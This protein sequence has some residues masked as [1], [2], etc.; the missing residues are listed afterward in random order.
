M[1][2]Q[3]IFLTLKFKRLNKNATEEAGGKDAYSNTMGRSYRR[4][5]GNEKDRT[6]QLG[7]P[8]VCGYDSSAGYAFGVSLITGG[9]KMYNNDYEPP[10]WHIWARLERSHPIVYEL[11]QIGI[12]LMMA[13]ALIK[14][15]FF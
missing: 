7:I 12:C 5:C 9:E 13:A 11:I 15:S 3:V 2:S 4:D 10:K 8:D 14:E 1:I 6:A